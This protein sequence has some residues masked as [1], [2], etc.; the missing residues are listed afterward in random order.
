MRNRFGLALLGLACMIPYV[1][2]SASQQP[3][4]SAPGQRITTPG[5]SHEELEQPKAKSNDQ[6]APQPMFAAPQ[7]AAP[8]TNEAAQERGQESEVQRW[9]M[10]F[11][12]ALVLVGLL[13]VGSMIWQ[14]GLLRESNAA[15]R[16][17]ADE[18]TNSSIRIERAYL[19][20]KITPVPNTHE[21]F[22]TLVGWHAKVDWENFGKTAAVRLRTHLGQPIIKKEDFVGDEECRYDPNPVGSCFDVPPGTI[23]PATMMSRVLTLDELQ[24]AQNGEIFI[25]LWGWVEYSNIFA[26]L[27]RHR[28]EFCF[29]ITPINDIRTMNILFVTRATGNHNGMDGTCLYQ[30]RTDPYRPAPYS[31][32]PSA[33]QNPNYGTTHE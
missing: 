1:K 21:R 24:A 18:D 33:P 19:L 28:T 6:T 14:A 11:T 23:R 13:Q 12:G 30:P 8:G 20:P 26:D 10:Y 5:G 4:A 22:N 17:I 15:I 2:V 9:L 31:Q 7:P 27:P 29:R 25:F 3:V 32:P 16:Q